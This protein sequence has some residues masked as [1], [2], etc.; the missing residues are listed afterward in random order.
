MF[1]IAVYSFVVHLTTVVLT[2]VYFD[3]LYL[4]VVQIIELQ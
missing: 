1:L 4:V 2:P 3:T